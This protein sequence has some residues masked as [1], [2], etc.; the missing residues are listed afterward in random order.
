MF[1]EEEINYFQKISKILP[2]MGHP[3]VYFS[4]VS[5]TF[6]HPLVS[7]IILYTPIFFCIP[8]YISSFPCILCMPL[9][10]PKCPW[11]FLACPCFCLYL[12]SWEFHWELPVCEW[13]SELVNEWV[14][15][16]VRLQYVELASQLKML[17]LLALLGPGVLAPG[18]ALGPCVRG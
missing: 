11:M 4:L 2:I 16:W 10:S 5:I 17:I 8:L 3:N 14:S 18:S 9:H 7:I 12:Y 13:L 1:R 6:P 15:E